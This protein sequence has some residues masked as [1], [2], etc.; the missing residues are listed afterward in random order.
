[1]MATV[2]LA[3]DLAKM[4]PFTHLLKA[5]TV[6]RMSSTLNSFESGES[7]PGD[8]TNAVET[9]EI[10]NNNDERSGHVSMAPTMM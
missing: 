5:V 10:T 6:A 7:R 1:M 8:G 2:S 4:S 3:F 9:P